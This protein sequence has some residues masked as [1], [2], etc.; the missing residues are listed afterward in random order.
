MK[1]VLDVENTVTKR[2][3]KVHLDP[4][5]PTN[6]L[7]QV[8]ML[9]ADDPKA[10][11][12]I[13]TLDHNEATDFTGF[14]RLEVQW[15][16]DNTDLLIMHNAQHDLM[17]LW[18]CGFKYDGDIY[19]T[20]LGEYILD[21]GQRNPLSLQ[22]CAERRQLE[23]QKDDT[24]K[25]YFKEGK[26]TNEIPLAELCHYLKHDLLTTSELFQAQEREFLLP[27]A[28]SLSTIKRVTFNTCKTLTEIY[29]AGFKVDLQ[30]LERVAKEFENEKIGRA[31]V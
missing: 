25:R 30:E 7:V 8:G 16:L 27:E 20:M 18:Q 3:D 13:K 23:V 10:T 1:L 14:Q 26:N 29:M 9:D 19:D 31:H 12:T 22:A 24:L 11:L 17:W 6:H 5:E 2:D 15:N 21:R 4:F 28:S